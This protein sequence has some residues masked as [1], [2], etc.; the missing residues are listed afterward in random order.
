MS[1]TPEERIKAEVAKLV[2]EKQGCKVTELVVATVKG[3]A[4]LMDWN[5]LDRIPAIVDQMIK[6]GEILEVEFVLP[7][8][9]WRCKSFLLPK[10]T[11]IKL[12]KG[13]VVQFGPSELKDESIECES[14]GEVTSPRE[15]RE[16]QEA[17][18]LDASNIPGE[19]Q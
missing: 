13:F 12:S 8:M 3:L 14:C 17:A 2:T 10:G 11:E 19:N 16:A 18:A 4:N 5:E 9:S 15:A 7:L 6:E 1:K